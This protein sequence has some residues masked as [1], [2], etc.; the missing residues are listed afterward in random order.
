MA[1]SWFFQPTA[2]LESLVEASRLHRVVVLTGKAGAAKSSLATALARPEIACGSVP[3]GIVHA[4]AIF[5][6]DTNPASLGDDHAAG[7]SRRAAGYRAPAAAVSTCAWHRHPLLV[8]IGSWIE[9]SGGRR[10]IRRGRIVEVQIGPF[11]A[12][13]PSRKRQVTGES[14]QPG[15]QDDLH[16]G[17][18]ATRRPRTRRLS[19]GF[20]WR[21]S[22][23][24]PQSRGPARRLRAGWRGTRTGRHVGDRDRGR[25]RDS[26]RRPDRSAAGDRRADLEVNAAQGQAADVEQT[27]DNPRST[28]PGDPEATA[29]HDRHGDGSS[30]GGT[31]PPGIAVRYFGD[32]EIRRELGRGGMGVVYEARQAQPEPARR[33]QDA[34]GRAAR[35]RGRAPEV[36]E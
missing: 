30:D 16:F 36:P 12:Y 17:P 5:S 2:Q 6:S 3:D 13:G 1:R 21:R 35:R 24:P 11:G 31:L 20:V 28:V 25:F 18:R 7:P 26:R 27:A 23:I 34:Q 9:K 8:P 22:R 29:A 4:I 10:C 33:A 15:P 14:R 19:G 32:Y